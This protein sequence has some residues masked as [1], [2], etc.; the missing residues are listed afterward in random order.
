M[1]TIIPT[2]REVFFHDDDLIVSKTD[3]NGKIVYVNDIF[4]NVSGYAEAELINRPHSL[5][6]HPDMPR[7]IFK[8]LWDTI[9]N[10]QEIFAYVMNMCKSGDHY[11]VFAH[12]TPTFDSNNRITGFHSNRRTPSRKGLASIM[13]L[14]QKLVEEEKKHRDGRKGLAASTQLLLNHLE[15]CESN[16][17]EFIF[18][19]AT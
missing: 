1:S 4:I 10:G 14:Y 13:E 16:Y 2:G 3:V 9:Q 11:W 8:L 15:E 5:I 17:E 18:Q 6:R 19:E 7:A 12:V